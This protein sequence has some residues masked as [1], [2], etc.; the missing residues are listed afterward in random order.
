MGFFRF[1]ANFAMLFAFLCTVR[2]HFF[3]PLQTPAPRTMQQNLKSDRKRKMSQTVFT[4]FSPQI[5]ISVN[6]VN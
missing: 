3:S 2:V 1:P 5:I 6:V 4:F